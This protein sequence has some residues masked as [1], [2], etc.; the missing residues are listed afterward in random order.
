M[1][2]V[3]D[4]HRPSRRAVF[5]QKFGDRMAQNGGGPFKPVSVADEYRTFELQL[6][7]ML[8]NA[9]MAHPQQPSPTAAGADRE[10]RRSQA[11]LKVTILVL[12]G[13]SPPGFHT[14][15]YRAPASSN[16]ATT[17]YRRLCFT[18]AA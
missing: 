8:Q 5:V 16:A 3:M 12:K 9:A 14:D 7:A 11:S 10:L 17:D 4:A 1:P 6:K 15:D 18:A 2:E 13:L